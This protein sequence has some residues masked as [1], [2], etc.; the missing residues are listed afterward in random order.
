MR[1]RPQW[2]VR[3][4]AARASPWRL[5]TTNPSAQCYDALI[6][7]SRGLPVFR[8]AISCR[9][10]WQQLTLEHET[11]GRERDQCDDDVGGDKDVRRDRR[12][13]ACGAA[14]DHVKR[15]GGKRGG[16]EREGPIGWGKRLVAGPGP[17]TE[18]EG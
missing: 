6:R 12:D 16:A 13:G 14:L 17:Q 4:P 11:Q 2:L 3:P 1:S 18:Q 5:R 9:R 10:L 8:P 7:S 15:Y